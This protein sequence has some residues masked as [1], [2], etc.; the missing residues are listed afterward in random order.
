MCPVFKPKVAIIDFS[1][2]S[3]VVSSINTAPCIK[4]VEKNIPV[5]ISLMEVSDLQITSDIINEDENFAELSLKGKFST[6]QDWI[7][8]IEK[9]IFE[10]KWITNQW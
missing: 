2:T 6:E 3:P 1:S 4:I 5:S 9:R 10:S 7:N 8:S